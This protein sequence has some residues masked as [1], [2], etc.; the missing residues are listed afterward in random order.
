MPKEIMISSDIR[1]RI[2]TL[3]GFQV[4]IDEDLAVLYGTSTMRLNEQVKRNRARFPDQFCFQLTKNEYVNLRSQIA[5]SNL[6]SQIA[7]SK[8]VKRGGRRKLPYAFTEQGVAMLSGVLKSKVAVRVSI[9]IMSEFVAMRKV[10]QSNA[11]IFTRLDNIEQ[12]QIEADK[13]IDQVF[14]ALAGHDDI[15]KQKLY[16]DGQVFDAH[17]FVSKL[18][19]TAKTKIILVD[20]FVDESV[21]M[22]LT[23]RRKNVSAVIYCGKISSELALDVKKHNAQY[24]LIELKVLTTAHDRFLIIDGNYI[25]HFGASI[26]DLGKKWCAVSKIEISSVGLLQRLG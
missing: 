17:V 13:K 20:N 24:P 10:I 11:Q 25:Y 7:I 1:Q 23:K 22:L 5:T 4:M 14:N 21:L 8:D 16:F 9:Q 18:I 6:I 3:R 26:K 2:Y 12:K 19:R 15:P